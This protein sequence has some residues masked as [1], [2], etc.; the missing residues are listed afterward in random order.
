MHEQAVSRFHSVHRTQAISKLMMLARATMQI[1]V[2][3]TIGNSLAGARQQPETRA[4]QG[5]ILTDKIIELRNYTLQPG[6][7]DT[8]IDL[9]EREFVETQEAVGARVVATFRDI[10]ARDHFVWIRSFAD[11]DA[12]GK[13]LT[14][15]Y[16]GPAWH[17]NSKAANATMVDTDNVHMLHGTGPALCLPGARPSSDATDVLRTLIVIDIYALGVHTEEELRAQ[18]S[19]D[20]AIIGMFATEQSPNNFPALP[21]HS[22][23]V[24]VT[25]RRF[26]AEQPVI[27]RSQGLPKP[28][29]T[30]RLQPTVRSLLR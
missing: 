22:N 20:P 25:M 17:A 5:E 27:P 21:V 4:C 19:R 26:D 13:A 29:Q 16:N 8:L 24:F 6:K 9:F 30:L 23:S 11:L 15:F 10:D 18:A 12:R 14:A 1:I 28:E 2:V 3:L 7:R